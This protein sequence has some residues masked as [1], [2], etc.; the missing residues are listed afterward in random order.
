LIFIPLLSLS[1]SPLTFWRNSN[2]GTRN[3]VQ[4]TLIILTNYMTTTDRRIITSYRTSSQWT[5]TPNPHDLSSARL[6]SLS[7]IV[8]LGRSLST[9]PSGD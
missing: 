4:F 8:M 7:T 1:L 5:M 2:A 6:S 3:M 9:P